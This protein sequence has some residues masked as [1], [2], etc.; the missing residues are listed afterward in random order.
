MFEMLAQLFV[1]FKGK[2]YPLAESRAF[3]SIINMS[4]L[5]LQQTNKKSHN[6]DND[7]E[8]EFGDHYQLFERENKSFLFKA[9]MIENN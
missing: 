4:I 8:D 3:N 6:R 5:T 7:D 9:N 1:Q 2:L